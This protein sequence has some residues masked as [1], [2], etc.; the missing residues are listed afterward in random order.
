M[1]FKVAKTARV[2]GKR[3]WRKAKDTVL[4]PT[5]TDSP[6][7]IF[8]ISRTEREAK[9]PRRDGF[10]SRTEF[11]PISKWW[12]GKKLS[13]APPKSKGLRKQ[14]RHSFE[15]TRGWLSRGLRASWERTKHFKGSKPGLGHLNPWLDWNNLPLYC[16]PK[17]RVYSLWRNKMVWKAS[18]S[19][20]RKT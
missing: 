8:S 2:W 18:A 7:S 12:T 3:F 14:P 15:N 11:L 1:W 20:Y 10:H 19:S 17:D 4:S 13:S 16:L 9:K 6:R 5:L